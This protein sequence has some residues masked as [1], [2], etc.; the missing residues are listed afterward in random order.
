MTPTYTELMP[1]ATDEK[2]MDQFGYFP[3]SVIEPEPRPDWNKV[4]GDDGDPRGEERRGDAE[5]LPNLRFSRFHPDLAEFIVRYWSLPGDLVVDPFSGRKTRAIVSLE[6]G[7][8]YVGYE[9]APQ[10]YEWAREPI[11]EHGGTL[12]RGDG[13][14][15]EGTD[16][17]STDLVFTC[18][19][20]H[21]LEKY[22]SV[23][24]QLSDIKDY[25]E[26]LDRIEVA[27][28]NTERILKPGRFACWVVG[29]WRSGG[30]KLFHKDVIE[31]ME[32]AGLE[33]WDVVVIRNK[34]PL[35]Y[36]QVGKVASKRYTSKTHEYLLVFRKEGPPVEGDP[37]VYR[38]HTRMEEFF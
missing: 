24:E 10:T 28:A 3:Y 25:G 18:P 31:R 22:E 4:I 29:D 21:Q 7:R 33:P 11:E 15:M 17:E 34:S 1:T 6:L 16:D 37:E 19:P 27:C 30:L 32:G 35:A 36:A 20:Y 2:V 8:D 13:C 5:W 12:I 26:F 9:V 23:D 38:G 14:M